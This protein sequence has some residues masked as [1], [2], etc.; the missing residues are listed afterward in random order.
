MSTQLDLTH[1]LLIA[2]PAMG[3]AYFAKSVVYVLQHDAD[4][5]FGLII[6][7]PVA[8][9][10]KDLVSSDVLDQ[11]NELEGQV[12]L[13]DNQDAP[14]FFG[15]PVSKEQGFV[16]HGKPEGWQNT[17]SNGALAVTTSIDILQAMTL[18]G[19]RPVPDHKLITVGYSGWGPDQLAYEMRQNAWLSV[20]ADND[21]V[22]HSD[23]YQKYD[24]ALKKLGI[25]P[26]M[27]SSAAG[28]A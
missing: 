20:E 28:R 16:L 9:T 11:A 24:L 10:L 26:A 6:N 8:M 19:Q 18:S 3:D 1:H 22:F 14:V 2:M 13:G 7:K 23:P 27:M 5:S 15:G 25:D 17:L 21:I 12:S 4:G